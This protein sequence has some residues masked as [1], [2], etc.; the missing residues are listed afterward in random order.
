MIVIGGLGGICGGGFCIGGFV[1]VVW[2]W[3][4]FARDRGSSLKDC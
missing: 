3:G 2:E 1:F 4:G